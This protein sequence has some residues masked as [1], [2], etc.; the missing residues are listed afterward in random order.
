MTNLITEVSHLSYNEQIINTMVK[1][2]FALDGGFGFKI[3][4]PPKSAAMNVQKNPFDGFG[5]INTT[6]I[7]DETYKKFTSNFIP[8][9]WEAKFMKEVSAF[10]LK[11][12]EIHQA[13]YLNN[14]LK[15]PETFSIVPLGIYA[16]RGEVRIYLFEWEALSQLYENG[17]SIHKKFL[18]KL[19]FNKVV[20]K[21]GL[22]SIDHII[23]KKTLLDLYGYDIYMEKKN[24]TD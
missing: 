13:Y 16:K 22:F 21:E 18:E 15:L 19:P 11:R 1:K 9:Y 20:L 23:T 5:V 10:A 8:F 3:S 14:T 4:D 24:A 7:K 12:I 17:F 6:L 2:S